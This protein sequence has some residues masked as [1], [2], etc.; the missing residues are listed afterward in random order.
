[1]NVCNFIGRIGR[2]AVQRHTPSGKS[3]TNWSIAVDVGYGENKQTLW[4]DCTLWGERGEKIADYIRNGDKIGVS[5]EI[6]TR[7]HDG[8][9]YM[10]LNVREVEL[11]GAKKADQP[12]KPQPQ[13]Q[14]GP[15]R[16]PSE[17]PS[18]PGGALDEDEIP[19][20]PR[21]KRSHWE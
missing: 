12:E 13:R 20:A 21:G 7:E 15:A 2:D 1:M 11:L 18:G 10:T 8:K 6:G 5:G 4:I 14:A 17:Q 3:V 16:G 19:F 9:T